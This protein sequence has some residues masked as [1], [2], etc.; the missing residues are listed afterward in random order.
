M[1]SIAESRG[2]APLLLADA[3]LQAEMLFLHFIIDFDSSAWLFT[4][5][6]VT[7]ITSILGDYNLNF[8][9]SKVALMI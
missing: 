1:A 2:E 6:Q 4:S 8:E 3:M 7:S 9:E 5:F